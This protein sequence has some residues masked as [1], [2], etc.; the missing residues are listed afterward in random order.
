MDA[1]LERLSCLPFFHSKASCMQDWRRGTR[2]GERRRRVV[3]EIESPIILII[4]PFLRRLNEVDIQTSVST[5]STKL[6]IV[7]FVG[8]SR[9]SSAH[10][11]S[12]TYSSLAYFHGTAHVIP[13]MPLPFLPV[14]VTPLALPLLLLPTLLSSS[15]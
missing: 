6:L 7:L 5:G 4:V 9:L 12:F 1:R 8:G 2:Q 14:L 11:N 10:H 13:S 3:G 15:L